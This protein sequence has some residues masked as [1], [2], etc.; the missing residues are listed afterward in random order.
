MWWLL[1]LSSSVSVISTHHYYTRPSWHGM[2]QTTGTR[3]YLNRLQGNKM[4]KRQPPC[5]CYFVHLVSY[6]VQHAKKKL[7]DFTIRLPLI[8]NLIFNFLTIVERQFWNINLQFNLAVCVP[9]GAPLY[10]FS[11]MVWI[12]LKSLI[13]RLSLLLNVTFSL[14]TFR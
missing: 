3:K 11:A 4:Q 6:R 8:I 12:S 9:K 10:F 5:T 13:T 7:V 1:S 14:F 2:A